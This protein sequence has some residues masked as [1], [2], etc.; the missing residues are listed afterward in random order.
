MC[1][2]HPWL[3]TLFLF[4]FLE[5][6]KPAFSTFPEKNALC[7]SKTFFLAAKHKRLTE[8]ARGKNIVRTILA[9]TKRAVCSELGEQACQ[10]KYIFPQKMESALHKVGFLTHGNEQKMLTKTE[11][12]VSPKCSALGPHLSPISLHPSQRLQLLPSSG[13]RRRDSNSRKLWEETRKLFL[14]DRGGKN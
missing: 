3:R 7:S 2:T 9:T 10:Q 11:D 13:G 5:F 8:Q 14:E 4:F 12:F 6:T 1:R